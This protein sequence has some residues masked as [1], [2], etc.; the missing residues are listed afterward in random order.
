MKRATRLAVA[1]LIQMRSGQ[2][3]LS[4]PFRGMLIP[5]SL[6]G[7]IAGR[8]LLGTHELEL[9]AVLETLVASN[10]RT[11][12]N[13]GA[14]QG[15]YA[16]GLALRCPG[17]RVTAY[18]ADETLHPHI[19]RA[20][21]LNGVGNRVAV[22]GACSSEALREI[23]RASPPPTVVIA[24]IDGGERAVFDRGTVAALS[25]ATVLIETH[26]A[27]VQG[28]SDA[29]RANFGSSHRA[30]VVSPRE[31]TVADIPAGM[32]GGVWRLLASAL[33]WEM[34]EG[35]PTDQQWLLFAPTR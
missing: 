32:A 23:A 2:R 12:I 10:P 15:Y 29:L 26:D 9:H 18:E 14:A 13:C 7:G 24:D 21:E 28:T 33:L 1:R 35:R 17:A 30:E 11:I 16:I 34:R 8:F 3:V 4:G 31:R 5:S 25:R 22:R 27:R 6:P 19:A 20:A